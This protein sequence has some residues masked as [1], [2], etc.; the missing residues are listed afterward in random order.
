[1][2]VIC[3]LLGV[4]ARAG[5][6]AEGFS[7]V[8]V[9]RAIARGT[10]FLWS[11][12]RGDG[13]WKTEKAGSHSTYPAGPTSICVYAL[14]ESGVRPGE[15]RLA[16]ALSYLARTKTDATY[17]LGFR[18]LAYAAMARHAP[19]YQKPLRDDVRTLLR[20]VGR[21]GGYG[22]HSNGRPGRENPDES[23]AQYGLLGVWAGARRNEEIPNQYWRL[24]L[25]YWSSRQH[26]DGGWGYGGRKNSSLTMTLAG[27]ASAYVCFDN[28]YASRF[29]TCRPNA[30]F[31]VAERGLAW[32]EKH[33]D[34]ISRQGQHTYYA[35]YGVERVAL[36]TGYKY[37]GQRDWYR[38]GATKLIGQ[39]EADGSWKSEGTRSGGDHVTTAYALLFLVR[40]RRPVLLNRL[41]YDGDWNNRPRALANLTRWISGQFE[42][43]VHWQIV[44]LKTPVVQWHD[45]PILCITGSKKPKFSPADL[46]KLHAYVQQGGSILSIAECGGTGFN[47]GVRQ[48][49]EK[50]F[51]HDKLQP[52]GDDHDVYT[53]YHALRSRPKLLSVSNGARPLWI[54]SETDLALAW[55]G[56]RQRTQKEAFDA[57]VNLV[58]YTNDKEALAGKLRF[59]GTT[60]WP[61]KYTG[62]PR[63]RMKLARLKYAG[64]WDPEPL[65]YERFAR[66]LGQ[67]TEVAVEVVSPVAIPELS[68]AGA[69]LAT[70]TGTDHFELTAAEKAGLKRHVTGGGSLLLDAAGGSKAFRESAEVLLAELFGRRALRS[71]S[72]SAAVYAIKGFEIP[73]V[74]YRRRTRGI[75]GNVTEPSL[76]AVLVDK[77]RPGVYFSRED[78]TVGLV[79]CPSYTVHGYAPHS[80]YQIVRNVALSVLGKKV[81]PRSAR[82]VPRL[83]ASASKNPNNARLAVDGQKSTR[84]ST[85]RPMKK[86]DWFAVDLGRK[87]S[88]RRIVLNAGKSPKDYPRGYKVYLSSDGHNWGRSVLTGQGTKPRVVVALDKPRAT[89]HVRIVLTRDHK[90]N[91]W[92]LCELTVES[93]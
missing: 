12:Q 69:R 6:G 78:L 15:K 57:A 21:S 4:F 44:N 47:Q 54:H 74:Q 79:G 36:A 80:A 40:G 27:L 37:F 52:L 53:A 1:M 11:R 35:L 59:R 31:P 29:L 58:A 63:H 51:G 16:K 84:W 75:L 7:D 67:E 82:P 83:K 56:Q 14:L 72:S 68:G 5:R 93:E 13:S 8:A 64:N 42:G 45:A 81:T 71:L 39:Q 66:L 70:M 26:A 22:Y 90:Q 88:I 41:K 32:L 60:L 65:A 28:L 61:A 3:C 25:K 18:C 30:T 91:H 92:T 9:D 76:R 23:N 55:Q 38:Y 20:S 89:R 24:S 48:A 17:D 86:G 10:K 46:R 73:N 87:R 2:A 33:F 19:A 62:K 43:D 77:A 34:A 49:C 85:G 50:L